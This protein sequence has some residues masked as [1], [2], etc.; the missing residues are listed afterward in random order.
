MN[1]IEQ[2]QQQIIQGN[3]ISKEQAINLIDQPL[4]E[5]CTAADQIRRHFC[6]DNFD[7]CT[8]IN[9]KSGRCSEDCKYC[10][11][12]A[13]YQ[14]AIEEY[15]LLGSKEILEQAIYNDDRGVLRYSLVTSGR[16]LA[17]QEVDEVCASIREVRQKT[18]IKVCVSLGLLEQEQFAKLRQAGACR[19]HNNLESSRDNFPNICTT[20]TYDDKIHS[21]KAAQAAGLNV[22]SG[23][24]MGLGES[25]LDRINMVFDIRELGIHSIPVN[26]LNPIPGTPY[27]HLPRLTIEDMRRIV[28]IFRFII[29]NAYIRL[30]GGRGM[31]ADKGRSCFQSG[32]N[33]CIS[34]DMLT[35]AG[36]SIELDMQM[37]HE[38]GYKA[39][40][41][42]E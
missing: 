19:V 9:A 16:A 33:A 18:N 11:Q 32:A 7:I 4:E 2:L 13:Y 40:L 14:T 23:G 38:L 37:L 36:I 29:P 15:P 8:I 34:G 39:V 20:H 1:F 35:T 6:Q 41:C 10:S 12:S 3:Q 26:M 21:I 30:A 22:C 5:L 24:I 28:A 27:A 25:M 17:D 31:L 42:D